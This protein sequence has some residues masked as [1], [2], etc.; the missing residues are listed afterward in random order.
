MPS[1]RPLP[2]ACLLLLACDGSLSPERGAPA[3]AQPMTA[4]VSIR[5]G[6]GAEG[7]FRLDALQ[8]LTLEVRVRGGSPGSNPLR[9][10]VVTPGGTLYAQLPLAVETG[11]AGE[12]TG[13]TDLQVGGTAIDSYRQVGSWTVRVSRRGAAQP[14]ATARA[15][16]TD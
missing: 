11:P 16:L 12:G 3:G 7:P 1:L 9:L 2:V 4:T 8:R 14:L 10:D 15:E 13:M 5:D 6:N